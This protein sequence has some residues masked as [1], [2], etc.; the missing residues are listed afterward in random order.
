MNSS[1]AVQRNGTGGGGAATESLILADAFAEFISASSRL[2]TFYGDLQKE[3][4]Q[5]GAELAERNASLHA[6]LV[7]SEN[8]VRLLRQ[9]ME[10]LPCA[11]VVMDGSGHISFMNAEAGRLLQ[12]EG[13]P[14]SARQLPLA[15]MQLIYESSAS[16]E[17]RDM[18]FNIDGVERQISVHGRRIG[19]D[20]PSAPVLMA[21]VVRD[22]S[23]Q[24]A[25]EEACLERHRAQVVAEAAAA[26]AEEI[27]SPLASIEMFTNLISREKGDP[28]RWIAHLRTSTRALADVLDLTVQL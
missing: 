15:W 11:V 4:S 24:R 5:L 23:A 1:H 2:E 25:R 3:V 19:Q 8:A 6:E 14:S 16:G 22:I 26:L 18:V 9:V 17:E 20:T 13:G 21:A 10:A 27:R 7:K 28:S 12:V